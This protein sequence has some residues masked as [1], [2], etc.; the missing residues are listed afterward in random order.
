MKIQVTCVYENSIY[1]CGSNRKVASSLQATKVAI[2]I[3]DL[4]T[5]VLLV[6]NAFTG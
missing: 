6:V 2:S 1:C 5:V 4:Q 3:R